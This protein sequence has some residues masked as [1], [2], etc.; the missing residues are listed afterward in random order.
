MVRMIAIKGIYWRVIPTLLS[1]ILLLSGCDAR[2]TSNPITRIYSA[3]IVYSYS[4][5]KA[6]LN[7]E[8]ANELFDIYERSEREE[9][10]QKADIGE[11]YSVR[12]SI[13]GKPDVSFYLDRNGIM[14]E[15]GMSF[16]I[17]S[18]ELFEH[19]DRMHKI[20]HAELHEV[21]H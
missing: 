4:S 19:I 2:E 8:E 9:T 15:E 17:Q 12:I 14:R 16:I 21:P 7:E 18:G 10:D 20:K 11:A 5:F 13:E 3:S 1:G 6:L